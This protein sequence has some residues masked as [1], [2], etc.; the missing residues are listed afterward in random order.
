M[1]NVLRGLDGI[2]VYIDDLLVASPSL[3][4]HRAQ[5]CALFDWLKENGLV[6]RPKKCD[7][8]CSELDFLG[9]H[10]DATRNCPLSAQIDVIHKFA[11]P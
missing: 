11:E 7:F 6:I 10:V 9:H 3:E 5:P 8:C 1:D 4:M 2:F